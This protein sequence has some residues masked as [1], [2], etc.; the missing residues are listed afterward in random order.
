MAKYASILTGD[1]LTIY[2]DGRAHVLHRDNKSF[3]KVLEAYKAQDFEKAIKLIDIAGTINQFSNGKVV[4]EGGVVKFNGVAVSN[5]IADRII[6]MG[7]EGFNVQPMLNFLSNLMENPSHRAVKELYLFLEHGKLPITE[8]GHFLAYKRVRPDFLDIYT[9][10][11]SNA[12]GQVVKMPRNKV[13][14]NRDNTC[15]EGLHFCSID[16]LPN[17]GGYEDNKVVIVKVNPANVVSIP[18]DYNNTKGRTCEYLVLEEYTGPLDNSIFNKTVWLDSDHINPSDV[19]A[20]EQFENEGGSWEDDYWVE[21]DDSWDDIS[22]DLSK[23]HL[24]GGSLKSEM[25][26]PP[27]A[28]VTKKPAKPVYPHLIGQLREDEMG[29]Q[30]KI[31][32]TVRERFPAGSGEKAGKFTGKVLVK[33]E[34]I[35]PITRKGFGAEV[36]APYEEVLKHKVVEHIIHEGAHLKPDNPEEVHGKSQTPTLHVA[37]HI[38]ETDLAIKSLEDDEAK[39]RKSDTEE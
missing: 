2:V 3:P 27:V 26:I 22:S 18:S 17:Y 10:T 30:Y 35:S 8:D 36:L 14:D 21:E 13:D 33:C 28:V 7:N 20:V 1:A 6:E 37:T 39:T 32:D 11:I 31:I 29:V 23:L 12:P 9:G 19:A 5:V 4:V 25:Y 34:I 15:S 24:D 16:Y 38:S